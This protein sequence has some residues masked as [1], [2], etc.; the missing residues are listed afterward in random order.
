[1]PPTDL[2]VR[3]MLARDVVEAEQVTAAAYAL[4]GP[5]APRT[6]DRARRWVERTEHL[7]RTDPGGCWVAQQGEDLVGI[8]VAFRRDLLW[9]L[10]SYAVT[11]GL[12]G[13][14]I[15]RTLLEAALSHGRGCLRGMLSA[16]PD[17]RAYRRYRLAGFSLHPSLRLSGVVDRRVLPVVDH[18]REGTAADFALMDSVD[19]RRREAAHGVDHPLLASTHRLL[20]TDRTTGSGYAYLDGDGSP[21]LLAATNR[22]TAARLLWEALA[23]TPDGAPVRLDHVTQANEWAVDVALA[24]R[25]GVEQHGYLALRGM[26]PPTA[27]LHHGSL[28]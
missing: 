5:P 4:G 19:R 1:M 27:Y 15:G 28:L 11:P 20:V 9:L 16:S 17:P 13:T 10:A 18:V 26:A 6:P 8:A 2:L 24:A 7:R 3:P 12:Q 23:S 21:V 25:L 22:R 14:G